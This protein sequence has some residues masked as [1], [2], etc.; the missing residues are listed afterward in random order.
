MGM[1]L[2]CML[3]PQTGGFAVT[4]LLWE[5]HTIQNFWQLACA[6]TVDA[7]RCLV[8]RRPILWV[9]MLACAA[10]KAAWKA[11]LPSA[12]LHGQPL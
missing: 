7:L 5:V 6:H 9:Q 4:A 11:Q 1:S 10:L 12:L 8:C 2:L 3:C